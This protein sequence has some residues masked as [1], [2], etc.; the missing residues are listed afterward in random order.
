MTE[1]QQ[2]KV[3]ERVMAEL[4]GQMALKG[5]DEFFKLQDTFKG[6]HKTNTAFEESESYENGFQSGALGSDIFQG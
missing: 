2:R 6:Q 1:D 5:A 3:Q 4:E